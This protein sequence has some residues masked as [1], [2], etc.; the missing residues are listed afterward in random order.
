MD[1]RRYW[2]DTLLRVAT[3]VMQA[4]AAARLR[5]DMPVEH[6]IGQQVDRRHVSHLEALARTLERRPEMLDEAALDDE[7]RVILG[8]LMG[9]SKG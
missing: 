6:G 4:A 7:D 5:R 9:K 2:L 8:R 3:P 1:V